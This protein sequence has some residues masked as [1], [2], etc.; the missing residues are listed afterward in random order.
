MTNLLIAVKSCH[1]HAQQGYNEIIRE[2]WGKTCAP[3]FFMGESYTPG[4]NQLKTDEIVLHVK[5]NYESL[6]YKTREILK[7]FLL[8]A[9]LKGWSHIFLCDTDSYICP[10]RLLKTGFENYDVAGRFGNHLAVGTTFE[11]KD[12][13][14]NFIK[15]CHPWPSGGVGYFLSCKA[16]Q[17]VVDTKPMSWAEDFYVGQATG[18]HIQSGELKAVDL[19]DFEGYAAWHFPRRMYG[20]KVYNPSFRWHERM[21]NDCS[22]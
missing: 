14:G 21:Q 15:E 2:T 16:A 19:P 9:S 12:A 18:P 6:P 10:E 4:D 8:G 1:I 3:L 7:F 11:H 13:R 20:G 5:D 22:S 17:I